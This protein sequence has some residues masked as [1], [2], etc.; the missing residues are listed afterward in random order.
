MVAFDSY[1]IKAESPNFKGHGTKY[2]NNSGCKVKVL[3]FTCLLLCTNITTNLAINRTHFF[4][5]HSFCELGVWA[6]FS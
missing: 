3:C 1:V 6:E 5:S 4:L 2:N